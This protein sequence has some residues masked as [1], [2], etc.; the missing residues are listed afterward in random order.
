MEYFVYGRDR[1][2]AFPLKVRL[3]EEHWGFMDGYGEVLVAR[4]P[5]MTDD[6]DEAES[7]GSMHIVELVDAEAARAFAYDEP[8][9]RAG[10]FESV[11]L[12][13]FDNALGR[14]MWDFAD[15]VEDY[16][17][18]LVI[19][20]GEAG[21]APVVSKHVILYGDL[22]GLDDEAPLG[23]VALVEAPDQEAAASVLPAGSGGRTEVHLWY[24]GGRP[25]QG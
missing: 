8:Y 13:R 19:S 6:S 18:Y 16:N 20:M 5:T 7:T 2:G 10:A 9:Y 11:L 25:S 21:A 22:L 15:A 14:T 24:F 3:K 23:R 4:G 17:R 12:C 1:V